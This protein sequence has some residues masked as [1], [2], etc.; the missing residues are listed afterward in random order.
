MAVRYTLRQEGHVTEHGAGGGCEEA[1]DG[2]LPDVLVP[3]QFHTLAAAVA[4]Q[5]ERALFVAV[6]HDAATQLDRGSREAGA[7]RAWIASDAVNATDHVAFLDVCEYLDQSPAYWRRALG[8]IV[9][10]PRGRQLCHADVLAVRRQLRRGAALA[11][12]AT[13]YRR[14]LATI[15]A[16][17]NG[18]YYTL[19]Q[20]RRR[21]T[22]R[23]VATGTLTEAF[24]DE[25]ATT[26]RKLRQLERAQ[27]YLARAAQ[28]AA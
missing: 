22:L 20:R 5:P 28:I 2:C 15:A 16:I 11:A 25:I 13:E 9:P 7:V 27:V 10:R 26:R 24:N 17:A 8:Q 4:E 21:T 6:L 14:P 3:A 1:V 12:L 18:S 19:A 23:V